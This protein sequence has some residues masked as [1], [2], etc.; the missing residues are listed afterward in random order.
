MRGGHAFLDGPPALKHNLSDSRSA[1]AGSLYTA[2][3]MGTGPVL[4][5]S[6]SEL[7]FGPMMDSHPS[8]VSSR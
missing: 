1:H 4:K 2:S 6:G 5:Q 8:D 7:A 3:S